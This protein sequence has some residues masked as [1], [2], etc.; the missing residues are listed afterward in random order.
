M[1]YAWPCSQPTIDSMAVLHACIDRLASPDTLGFAGTSAALESV[2]R[3]KAK[4]A[5]YELGLLASADRDRVAQRA[6]HAST[7]Q[8]AAQSLHADLPA[9]ARQ[10][11]L[12]R[13][14]E[15]RTVTQT[16]LAT[17]ALSA[18]H[19]AVIVRADEQLPADLGPVERLSVERTLVEKARTMSPA[20]LRTA[21]R[22]SLE[23]VERD[24]AAVDAH[25][26]ELVADE[27][28]RARRKTRLTLHDNE[29]GTVTGHF[30]IPTM[31]GHLLRKVIA[32]ITAP[33]RGR[34]GASL[35]QTGDNTGLRT[36]W[37]RA[38]G[39]ALVE[40]IEHLPT[41]HLHPKTAAT[42]VVTTELASLRDALKVAGLDTGESLSAG[43][44]RRLACNAS[45]VPAVLGGKS[46][47]LDLGRSARLFNDT[48]RLAIGIA[49]QTCA[50]EGSTDP[51][52]GASCT[53]TSPGPRAVAPT[54]RRP[55]RPATSIINAS[56]IRGTATPGHQTDPSDS[57]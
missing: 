17:G 11:R 52:P 29:D 39:E 54:W 5:A 15:E 8:W 12:S 51:Q 50:A 41:D 7:S 40:L 43:E 57:S 36:D 19:A 32:T 37:D 2:A 1:I 6:G 47:P 22:R 25:E 34:L 55:S 13:R 23:A 48:Q 10:V 9:M 16:A 27:E 42:I 20:Q 4:L 44:V 35:A 33:R 56:M 31:H 45:L 46:L 26:N 49:H 38:R 53:T 24:V 28:E 14:L 30:T 21:A 18:E 3:A